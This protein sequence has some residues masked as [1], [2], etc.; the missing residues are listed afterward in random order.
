L[1]MEP[2]GVATNENDILARFWKSG[3][4]EKHSAAPEDL[5][6]NAAAPV[7]GSSD[8]KQSAGKGVKETL[9]PAMDI[10]ISSNFERLLWYLAYESVGGEFHVLDET[11]RGEAC[12]ILSSWM[13]DVK[14]DGRAV[15]PAEVLESARKDFVAERISDHQTLETI[16]DHFLV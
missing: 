7:G 5:G 9:S 3:K 2:L 15:V 1:P 16:K 6:S 8:G 11:K 14:K 12:K 4:Y 13:N 10:L